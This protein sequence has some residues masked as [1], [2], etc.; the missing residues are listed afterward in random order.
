VQLAT[1]VAQPALEQVSS[2]V[3]SK[4]SSEAAKLGRTPRSRVDTANPITVMTSDF[5][6]VPPDSA[7]GLS[8]FYISLLAL[9]CGFLGAVLVNSSIDAA[10]GYSTSEIGPRWRQRMPVAISRWQTLLTK[11]S[12]ALVAV[13]ILTGIL[14]LVAVG[15]L[16]MNAP[17]VGELWLFMSF[18]GI[19]IAAGTPPCSLL[20]AHSGSCL[21][22]S[23]SSTLPWHPRVAPSGASTAVVLPL[24]RQLRA[25]PASARRGPGDPV[26][27]RTADAGLIRGVVLTAIGLVFWLIVGAAVTRWYDRRGMDRLQP[28]VLEFAQRSA[29]AYAAGAQAPVAS[30]DPGNDAQTKAILP[31]TPH[32]AT[33]RQ[34]S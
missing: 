14:L 7:L 26:L 10:L 9:M 31:E 15:L 27:Q 13:P 23:C 11:W 12:V 17:Y 29:R 32:P 18:A 8:A 3:G 6:S 16:K 25:A 2:A 24:R 20:S 30:S 5:R 28:D 4:L 33:N 19:A 1:G 34:R 21:R 22:C